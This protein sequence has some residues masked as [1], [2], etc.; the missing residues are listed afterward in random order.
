MRITGLYAALAALLVMVLI[1]RVALR[2]RSAR[3]GIGDGGDHE[4]HK[5]IR[6][7][8]NA[9]EVLPLGLILLL[10]VELNQTQPLV[11]H[12][13]GI[14]L[15]LGRL[16]HAFGLSRSS[17]TSPGRLIGMLLSVL[18]IVAM[19]VL[20]LWQFTLGVMLATH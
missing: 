13:F 20:L 19:A 16:L 2:R 9:A 1:V 3:I 17:A 10:L 5:R 4:L 15:I 18:V 8:A 11:V 12:I 7:H 6:A 14:T